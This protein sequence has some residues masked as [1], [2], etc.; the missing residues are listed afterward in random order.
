MRRKIVAAN[1]KMNGSEGFAKSLISELKVQ[2]SVLDKDVKVVIIPPSLYV[3]E[4]KRLVSDAPFAV[5]I[6]NVAQWNQ[7][8]FTGEI[9]A[10][11]AADVGCEYVLVG[12]SE[13]RQ[14]F[15]ESD[16]VVA[17]K[18]QQVLKSGLVALVCVGETLAERQAGQAEEV[19]SRQLQIALQG[20]ASDKWNKIV[21]AYEPVWAIGT[22]KT[23]TAED[24]QAMHLHMRGVLGSLGAPASDISLLYGGSVK[25]ENAR[26]LF[27]QQDID[28]GLIGGAS[29]LADDF[30]SIC[31]AV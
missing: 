20:L 3:A 19:V 4:V 25:P 29:L 31:R 8:A 5:G 14:L 16:Q 23:A 26:E 11:M 22:G 24:A 18:V 7:G 21:V 17:E 6:Q 12:H 10:G 1:W 30:A 28:G 2:L 9:S 13:R 27:G 15:A